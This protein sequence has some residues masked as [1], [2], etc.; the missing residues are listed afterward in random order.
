MGK[1]IDN[2]FSDCKLTDS[3]QS[4]QLS[5]HPVSLLRCLSERSPVTSAVLPVLAHAFIL[6]IRNKTHTHTHKWAVCWNTS[7]RTKRP[8]KKSNVAHSTRWRMISKSCMSARTRSHSAP[9]M[10]IQ[11]EGEQHTSADVAN[12]VQRRRDDKQLVLK[13]WPYKLTTT[14]L[15]TNRGVYEP[16]KVS[17]LLGSSG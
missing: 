8:A 15:F 4:F 2:Y 16:I 7:I 10:A 5:T 12:D 3:V 14:E 13:I 11:P 9:K 17:V 6:F 1:E